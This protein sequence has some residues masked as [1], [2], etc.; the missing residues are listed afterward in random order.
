MLPL[1]REILSS[2]YYRRRPLAS[3][4]LVYARWRLSRG[5]PD[6]ADPTNFLRELGVE[7]A[8]ALGGYEGWSEH[9]LQVVRLSEEVDDAL[10]VAQ[11]D[12]LVLYGLVRALRPEFVVETGIATGVS[13]SFI[14]AALIENDAGRLYSIDLP[15]EDAANRS[16]P[17]GSRSSAFGPGWAVPDE[18]RS[19]IGN[20]H[21]V[22]LEDVRT[23]LPTLLGRLPRIDLFFHDDLHL[24]EHMLWQYRTVWP[25]LAHGGVLASDDI[26]Y[27]WL[28][29]CRTLSMGRR[30][31]FNLQR[32]GVIIKP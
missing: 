22:I 25:H 12:G 32:L 28:R 9:L 24:P 23:A 13:T 7:P 27:G 8:D 19:A 26:N 1:R 20:R 2:S 18:I 29:F 11:S 14:S 31:Y 3:V 21:E 4:Q 10:G 30:S 17:D 16:Y 15:S 6:P 5:Q